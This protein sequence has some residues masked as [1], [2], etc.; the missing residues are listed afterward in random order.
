MYHTLHKLLLGICYHHY[1][2]INYIIVFVLLYGNFLFD[3]YQISKD[4]YNRKSLIGNYNIVVDTKMM[5]Q[6]MVEEVP[7]KWL[8]TLLFYKT[9]LIEIMLVVA[10]AKHY[11]DVV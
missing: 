7:I 5:R 8:N 1:N 11:G 2:A 9:F 3:L 10:T 6:M 4:C